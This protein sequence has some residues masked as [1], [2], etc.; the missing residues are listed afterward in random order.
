MLQKIVFEKKIACAAVTNA[1]Q[2]LIHIYCK[3]NSI[4]G[5]VK[6]KKVKIGRKY[7]K[8]AN[9]VITLSEICKNGQRD[10]HD[11]QKYSKTANVMITI[12]ENI[13]SQPT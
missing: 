13:Q 6:A 2:I 8:T 1:L 11:C 10:D 3:K 7:P 9:V 12:A 4:F 5:N